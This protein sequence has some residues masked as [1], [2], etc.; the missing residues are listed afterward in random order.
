MIGEYRSG[1]IPLTNGSGSGSRRPK[2]MC[3]L[4]IRIQ[5]RIWICNTGLQV[6]YRKEG[7]PGSSYPVP[8]NSKRV[9][10]NLVEV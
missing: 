3:I 7:Q 1:L 6:L 4:W 9:P 8:L 5:I 2:N 10:S